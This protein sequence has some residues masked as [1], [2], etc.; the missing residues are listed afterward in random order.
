MNLEYVG[1]LKDAETRAEESRTSIQ[2]TLDDD[3]DNNNNNSNY[4]YYYYR[5]LSW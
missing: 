5:I 2:T 4:Y 3:D 1:C